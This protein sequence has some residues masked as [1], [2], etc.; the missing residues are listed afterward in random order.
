MKGTTSL[1]HFRN[2]A[3]I[4]L[5]EWVGHLKVVEE[6]LLLDGVHGVHVDAD[7][8]GEATATDEP[9]FAP[10]LSMLVGVVHLHLLGLLHQVHL[11]HESTCSS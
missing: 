8:G 3:A 4:L 6:L 2:L 11:F 1:L 10:V 7:S 9:V 5:L